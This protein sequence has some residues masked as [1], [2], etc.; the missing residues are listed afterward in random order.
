MLRNLFTTLVDEEIKR[1][2]VYRRGF[3][4]IGGLNRQN[5]PLS[6]DLPGTAGFVSAGTVETGAITTPRQPNGLV[7]MTPGMSIGVATPGLPT[8]LH[9]SHTAAHLTPTAEEEPG[10]DSKNLL[11]AGSGDRASDYFSS[12]PNSHQSEASSES[13]KAPATPSEVPSGATPASPTDDKE[14][15]KKGIFGKNFKMTFPKNM[16]LGRGSNE[17]K[18]AAAT[19]EKQEDMS[20][21]SSEAGEKI[22]EDNLSGVIERIRQEYEEHARNN[23]DQP[24]SVGFTPSLP[25]ET[26]VLKPPPSTLVIIQ[27]DNPESGGVADLYR[28]AINTL[29]KD[30]DVVEKVAPAWL[31]ELLLKV[32]SV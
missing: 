13:N 20:D 8:A 19:E 14:E 31:G 12:N 16:K 10:G 18:P 2:E 28:G 17:A 32:C 1:D 3:R 23:T 11:Q 27:E 22:F 29:G 7:P 5:A 26:P 9:S 6:I 30:V 25:N 15:K 21:K 24:L 4:P